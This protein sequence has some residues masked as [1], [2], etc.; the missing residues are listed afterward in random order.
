MRMKRTFILVAA[1][2]LA[3]CGG[4]ASELTLPEDPDQVVLSVTSEGGFMPVEANLDRMPRYVVTADRSLYYVGPTT[5]EF[6]GPI[7]PNVQVTTLDQATIDEILRLVEEMG[8]PEVDEEV[9]NSGAEQIADASTEFIT[10]VDADGSHRMG[11]YALGISEGGSTQ[12]LLAGEIV[13]LLDEASATGQSRPY[14]PERLQVA[15]GPP[16]V[17]EPGMATVEEWPLEMSFDEMAEWAMDWRCAEVTGERVADL[18]EVF[19]AA[20]QATTWSAGNRT[21]GI[22][23][24][25]LLPGETAC[26]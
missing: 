19:S 22:R 21:L 7:L 11:F 4:A 1:L 25:P 26:N 5:M 23:A 15:A 6:P 2:A 12:R 14:Q 10:Y 8:L 24:R 9:D 17:V 13:D 20:N 18:V 3:S 16:M